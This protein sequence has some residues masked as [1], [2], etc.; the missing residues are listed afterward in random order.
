M[1]RFLVRVAVTT[2]QRGRTA[3]WYVTRPEALGVHAVVVTAAG[4]IVL[5]R[6]TYSPGWRLP[7]GGLKRREVPE[8]AIVRELREELRLESFG[9][10]HHICN[11]EHQ[12]EYR[13]GLAALF[14]VTDAAYDGRPSLEIE[15]FGEFSPSDLPAE[16]TPLTRI[17]I[18][19]AVES[20]FWLG[21][22]VGVSA[23][24]EGDSSARLLPPDLAPF[25]QR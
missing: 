8:A 5:V 25:E 15:A 21:P 12:P 10:L 18:E 11:F 24:R 22:K 7:G 20:D 17:L 19:A 2:F 9:A 16:A 1:W 23:K 4:K 6:Q 14:M 3:I 13:R